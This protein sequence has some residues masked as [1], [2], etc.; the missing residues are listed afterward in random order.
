MSR[1]LW[2]IVFTSNR[3]HKASTFF[4]LVAGAG[5]FVANGVSNTMRRLVYN[6]SDKAFRL[7]S[8][9]LVREYRALYGQDQ[10]YWA[11]CFA[12]LAFSLE[13]VGFACFRTRVF[14]IGS[15]C[16]GGCFTNYAAVLVLLV[17]AL[18]E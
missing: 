9:Q 18:E 2:R 5:L 13:I 15:E 8:M 1:P 14:R 7:L 17:R 10:N 12:W 16:N 4:L 11:Y 6:R 3:V